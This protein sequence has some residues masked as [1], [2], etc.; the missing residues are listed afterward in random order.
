MS[1]QNFT[2]DNEQAQEVVE[3]GSLFYVGEHYVT[4]NISLVFVFCT[5]TLKKSWDAIEPCTIKSECGWRLSLVQPNTAE[6][7]NQLFFRVGV[8][9]QLAKQWS[10]LLG[11]Y[12]PDQKVV[13][14]NPGD[15]GQLLLTDV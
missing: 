14:S 9:A 1:P 10:P 7:L 5:P 15:T 12:L 8:M 4:Y 2:V 13:S 3:L 6:P 11:N